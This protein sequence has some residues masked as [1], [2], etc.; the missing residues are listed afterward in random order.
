MNDIAYEKGYFF[1]RLIEENV[2]REKFDAFLRKYFDTFAF[3]TMTT[4]RFLAYMRENLIAGDKALEERLKIDQWING[5]GLPDNSPR[6]QSK[7][8]EQVEAQVKAWAEGTS[9]QSLQ[10][11]GWT[12]HHWQ[13]FLRKLPAQMAQQQMAELDSTFHFTQSGNSEILNEWFLR[14]IANNYSA[15]YPALENFLT[16]VGRR[17]FL[18]PLYTEMARSPE[19]RQMAR[20][21]YAKARPGYHSVSYTTI[22][23]ILK[24]DESVRRQ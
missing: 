14:A 10:T 6:P 24:W 13:H 8:F 12:S 4:D 2:G 11:S 3:Q 19:G 18:K 9:A 20:A 21:I 5:A 1:L 16:S 7:Q 23:E 15:A 17:K 22:D